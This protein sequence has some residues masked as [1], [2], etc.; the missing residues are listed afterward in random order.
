MVTETDHYLQW[1]GRNCRKSILEF[2]NAQGMYWNLSDQLPLNNQISNIL[3]FVK[4][5]VNIASQKNH[6]ISSSS[7]KIE[8]SINNF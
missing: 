2:K 8:K 6:L 4:V 1:L 7:M 5:L 3:W